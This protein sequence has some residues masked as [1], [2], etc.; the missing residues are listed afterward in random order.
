MVDY[1]AQSI[2][3]AAVAILVVEALLRLWRIEAPDARVAFRLLP[4]LFPLVVLPAF[5]ALAPAR[6]TE[7]FQ[8]RWAL[9]SS[10]RWGDAGAVALAL[11]AALGTGLFLLDLVRFLSR[12][13]AAHRPGATPATADLLGFGEEVERLA[14][15]FGDAPPRLVVLDTPGPILLVAGVRRPTLIVSAGALARL[16]ARERRAALTHELTHIARRDPL[17]GWVLMGCSVAAFFNP[18]VHV[19]V[20]LVLR[21]L[22]WRADDLAVAAGT[23]APVLAS[24]LGVFAAATDAA[25]P[26]LPAGLRARGRAAAAEARRRRLLEPRPPGARPFPRLGVAMAGVALGLLLFLVV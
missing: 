4:L 14:R 26:A 11:A 23:E 2:T 13:R 22:E 1:A 21:E 10:N 12:A 16:D 3:H 25:V 6:G 15:S 17:L 5:L 20:R 19:A 7:A 24:A 9:F 18:I 8:A